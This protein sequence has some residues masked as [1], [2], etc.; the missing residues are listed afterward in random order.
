MRKLSRDAADRKAEVV[1]SEISPETKDDN[2]DRHTLAYLF[3]ALLL[4]GVAAVAYRRWFNS[5]GPK[6]R[7]EKRHAETRHGTVLASQFGREEVDRR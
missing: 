4:S 3:S 6:R 1:I 5:H 2:M 7:R